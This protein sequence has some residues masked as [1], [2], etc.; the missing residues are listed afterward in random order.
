MFY[1]I[2]K[3]LLLPPTVFFVLFF[4]GCLVM[5]WRPRLGRA[6]LWILLALVYLTTTPFTAGEL[7]APL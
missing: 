1:K 4:A 6:V 3:T 7:M 5:K 2:L